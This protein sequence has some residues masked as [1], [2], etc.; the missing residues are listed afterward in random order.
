MKP[1]TLKGYLDLNKQIEIEKQKDNERGVELVAPFYTHL[2]KDDRPCGI[3]VNR[4][5]V[6][7]DLREI[8]LDYE[9]SRF[10]VQ[11]ILYRGDV[12]T[13][14]SKKNVPI[15]HAFW[16]AKPEELSVFMNYANEDEA[17]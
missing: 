15:H 16:S 6:P 17:S 9:T 11:G 12:S 10:T 14:E 8:R 1:V 2:D 5:W 3:L 4:G 13:R 7:R